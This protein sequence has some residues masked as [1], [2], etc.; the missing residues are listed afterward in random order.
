MT[1]LHP[2]IISHTQSHITTKYRDTMQSNKIQKTT[3]LHEIRRHKKQDN[4]NHYEN[5]R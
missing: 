1:N 4:M 2:S 3:Q 5:Q